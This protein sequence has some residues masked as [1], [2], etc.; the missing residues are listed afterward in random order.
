MLKIFQKHVLH[1]IASSLSKQH[2]V[3]IVAWSLQE[4]NGDPKIAFSIGCVS[5][6]L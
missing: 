3:L 2:Y 4:L 6:M 1:Q 5:E